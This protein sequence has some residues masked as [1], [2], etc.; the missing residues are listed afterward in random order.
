MK[1]IHLLLNAVAFLGILPSGE[2]AS[3]AHLE[4]INAN[5]H[6]NPVTPAAVNA[7]STS[8]IEASWLRVPHL[9]KA[10]HAAFDPVIT[11][12]E[13]ASAAALALQPMIA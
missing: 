11:G 4:G 7:A 5:P 3:A 1:P 12:D 6:R 13:T 8:A 10:R 9:C 2:T